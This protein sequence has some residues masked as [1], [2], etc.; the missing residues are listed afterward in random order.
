MKLT[1]WK[2][3]ELILWCAHVCCACRNKLL[4]YVQMVAIKFIS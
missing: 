1:S 4:H 2:N 3:T